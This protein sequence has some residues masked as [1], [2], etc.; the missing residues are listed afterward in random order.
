M[1]KERPNANY[2]LSKQDPSKVYSAD[3]DKLPFYYNRER[4]LAKAP[5]SVKN[6]YTETKK[7]RFGAFRLLFSTKSNAMLLITIVILC[8][9]IFILSFAGFFDTSYT[10]DG[11]KLLVKGI[12]YEETVIM[13]VIKNNKKARTQPY[14]GSVEMAVSPVSKLENEE[15]PVFYH[16]VFFTQETQEE[17]RFAVPFYSSELVVVLQTE[18]STLKFTV[19]PE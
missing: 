5:E 13:T 12:R 8:A 1:S 17:Y 19:K 18:K 6:L 14:T 4:R 3:D 9:F 7:H 16:R 2:N 10:I 15:Y 11:N